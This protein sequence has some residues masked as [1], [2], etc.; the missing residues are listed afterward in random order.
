M[1]RNYCFLPKK[2]FVFSIAVLLSV[3]V[4][5][6]SIGKEK[7]PGIRIS[8]DCAGFFS[9]R[10]LEEYGEVK[11]PVGTEFSGYIEIFAEN[12]EDRSPLPDATQFVVAPS[13]FIEIKTD[14]FGGARAS[15][16]WVHTQY[17]RIRGS[18]R[19]KFESGG[20]A[21]GEIGGTAQ[22]IAK[23]LTLV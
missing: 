23:A 14:D 21:T 1:S 16:Y 12:V 5:S 10:F 2:S 7:G 19:V 4:A 11:I 18:S 20:V 8:L 15:I 6:I 13:S 3:F 9:G 17:G 22:D